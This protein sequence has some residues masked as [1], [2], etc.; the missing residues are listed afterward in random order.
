MERWGLEVL[1]EH[2]I[3][4]IE[5]LWMAKLTLKQGV[6]NAQAVPKI[7]H[8][9]YKNDEMILWSYALIK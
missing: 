9:W 8:I 5:K 2:R 6:Q 4:L 3:S 7:L 1:Q